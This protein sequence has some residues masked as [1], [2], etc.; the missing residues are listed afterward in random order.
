MTTNMLELPK[1][2]LIKNTSRTKCYLVGIAGILTAIT[3]AGTRRAVKLLPKITA[4]TPLAGDTINCN[5]TKDD[6]T[7]VVTPA[8]TLA[9]LTFALPKA[10]DSQTGQT[11]RFVSSQIVTALT[12]SV[13]GSG[14]VSGAALTA[15]AANASYAFQCVSVQGAGTWMRIL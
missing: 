15:A 9:T 2:S 14:T 7:H 12:V 11:I 8:G 5:V 3:S 1:N 10:A 13:N 4:T 6:E